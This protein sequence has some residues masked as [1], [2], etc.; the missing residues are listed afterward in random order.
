MKLTVAR[1]DVEKVRESGLNLG[2]VRG[3]KGTWRGY[4]DL[5]GA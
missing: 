4:R 2:N 5:D 3:R 1:A